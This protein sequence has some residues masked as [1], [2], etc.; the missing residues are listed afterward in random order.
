VLFRS[1]VG[2]IAEHGSMSPSDL[3]QVAH[4][5]RAHVSRAITG[6]VRKGLLLRRAA[7]NDGRRAQVEL[8]ERGRQLYQDIFPQIARLSQTVVGVLSAAQLAA[9][10]EA[11]VALTASADALVR[12]TPVKVKAARYLGERR[13]V[14]QTP[15]A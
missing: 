2:L 13:R 3:A 9:F 5:E 15:A 6:L 7:P 10:E 14:Q 4:L 11:L 8:T 1:L 12:T